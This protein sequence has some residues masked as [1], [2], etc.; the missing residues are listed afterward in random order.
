MNGAIFILALFKNAIDWAITDIPPKPAKKAQK[1]KATFS[2]RAERTFMP[3]VH[4]KS[5]KAIPFDTVSLLVKNDI[6]D[7]IG[8]SKPIW[9][10]ISVR[11]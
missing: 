2:G 1:G 5:P 8:D 9:Y 7:I 11:R 10:N 4:S 3:L 6:V